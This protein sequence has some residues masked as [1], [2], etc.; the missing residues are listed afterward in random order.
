MRLIDAD[1]LIKELKENNCE[2]FMTD[3]YCF[4][5]EGCTENVIEL[6]NEQ[7]KVS[8]WIPADNP[9]KVDDSGMS[10][11]ILLSFMNF[12]VPLV[13]RYQ[14]CKD[15]SGAYYAGDS[16]RS[17]TRIGLF[18]NAWMKLPEPYREDIW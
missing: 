5:L 14:L 12:D 11:Y 18:V 13:G 16:D 7:P 2:I 17:C 4:G 1:K 10:D 15:G 6:V 3:G 8:E 9:P